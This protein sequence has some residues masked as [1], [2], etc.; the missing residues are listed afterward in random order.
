V[1]APVRRVTGSPP[2]VTAADD[3]RVAMAMAVAALACGPLALDDG[4]C[5]QKSFPGFWRQ[6]EALLS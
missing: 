6:W 4:D 5:V 2:R 1:H 3:H